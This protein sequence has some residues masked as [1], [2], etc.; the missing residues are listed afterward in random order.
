MAKRGYIL[1]DEHKRKISQSLLGKKRKPIS[2][3]HKRKLSIANT[4]KTFKHT[5]ESK[6]KMSITRK[7]R[8][9]WNKG[10]TGIYT[11][12]QLKKM[13]I[14][15]RNRKPA[16]EETRRKIS[17]AGKG[18][19]SGMLGKHCS[20]EHRRK[21]SEANRGDK[22][23]NW[24]GGLVDLSQKIRT[25]FKYRQWRSDVYTR[26]D[27][28][29][30]ECGDNKGGN[31]EA[32]HIKALSVIINEKNIKTIEDALNYEEV[33]N[34]NNGITLCNK[35][36]KKTDNYGGNPTKQAKPLS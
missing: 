6:L 11:E 28:T 1:S 23:V 25:C 4:G 14:S 7:G 13:S 20:P 16:S 9:P 12:E 19:P 18:R 2:E 27:F 35:C 15:Q 32:H 22:C 36:H 8:T 31:L 33:W 29:C 24:K 5:E 21:I 3:E 34:I 26:D 10:K 17:E 30:Q